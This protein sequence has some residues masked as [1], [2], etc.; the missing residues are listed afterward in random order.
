MSKDVN[1]LT[2]EQV[3]AI[4]C[5]PE[6]KLLIEGEKNPGAIVHYLIASMCAKAGVPTELGIVFIRKAML[7]LEEKK[8]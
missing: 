4:Q 5:T 7:G 1:T 6:W 2:K 3:I 8:Q